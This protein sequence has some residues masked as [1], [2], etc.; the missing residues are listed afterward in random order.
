LYLE[1]KRGKQEGKK[2]EKKEGKKDG[3]WERNTETKGKKGRERDPLPLNL[4][5]T[6]LCLPAYC[7]VTVID[8]VHQ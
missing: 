6:P 4:L 3:E 5:A 2:V 7:K 1:E 8:F